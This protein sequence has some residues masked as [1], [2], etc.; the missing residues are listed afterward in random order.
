[1]IKSNFELS[2]N[3]ASVAAWTR[4]NPISYSA[5]ETPV[6]EVGSFVLI[7]VTSPQLSIETAGAPSFLCRSKGN[8]EA[9]HFR[10]AEKARVIRAL[11]VG[12]GQSYRSDTLVP[13]SPFVD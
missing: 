3:S 8:P 4:S 9:T 12:T 10:V 13:Q 1:L 5:L 7:C 11:L 6:S 2:G